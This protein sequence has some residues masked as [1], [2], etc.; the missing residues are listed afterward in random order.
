MPP[1]P[2]IGDG[3]LPSAVDPS[4]PTGTLASLPFE[5]PSFEPEKA[6][7]ATTAIETI[8][9]TAPATATRVALI[10]VMVPR[11]ISFPSAVFRG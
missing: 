4:V 1:A 6:V 3:P 2:S 5:D 7:H 10:D 9:K 8:T 11:A